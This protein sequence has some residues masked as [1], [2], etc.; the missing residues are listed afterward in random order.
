MSMPPSPDPAWSTALATDDSSRTSCSMPTAPGRPAATEL[1]RWPDRPVSATVAPEVARAEAMASP[2]PLVPPVTSTFIGI[3]PSHE[4]HLGRHHR[5]ELHVGVHTSGAATHERTLCENA[6]A[7][8]R[9]LVRDRDSKFT[10]SFNA[11][12]AAEG[13]TTILTPFQAPRANAFAERWVRTVRRECLD[14]TLAPYNQRRPHR[15]LDLRSPDPPSDS[16][17]LTS[18][19]RAVR[20]HDLL[21]GLIDE[22]EPAHEAQITSCRAPHAPPA[23]AEE[24]WAGAPSLPRS[25]AASWLPAARSTVTTSS[26][27]SARRRLHR[28]GRRGTRPGR[29]LEQDPGPRPIAHDRRGAARLASRGIRWCCWGGT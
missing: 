22:Y 9:F 16:A 18:T 10:G 27:R 8:L 3:T 29:R 2:S 15:G 21:G 28:S 17:P 25:S 20:R 1:A 24:G 23:S 19:H 14:W 26:P 13:I 6:G 4:R 7:L 5:H 12:F 11:V